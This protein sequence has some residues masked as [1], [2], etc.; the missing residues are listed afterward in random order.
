ASRRGAAEPAEPAAE[1]AVGPGAGME[2][3]SLLRRARPLPLCPGALPAR[4]RPAPPRAELGVASEADDR[5]LGRGPDAPLHPA[6]AGGRGMVG[7]A[8]TSPI[9]RVR[10]R[11]WRPST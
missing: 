11:R 7:C 3:A 8:S 5:L 2:V 10:R 1:P 6:G 4:N 9:P